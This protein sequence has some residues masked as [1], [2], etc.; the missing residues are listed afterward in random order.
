MEENGTLTVTDKLN[1]HQY[2]DFN[3][4]ED[5]GDGGNL[6]NYQPV[7]MARNTLLSSPSIEVTAAN[8]LYKTVKV[9][10]TICCRRFRL[11]RQLL[12]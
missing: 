3:Y 4:F 2:R 6:Y 7:G 1:G 8:S 5:A 10:H 9:T 11:Y 12:H